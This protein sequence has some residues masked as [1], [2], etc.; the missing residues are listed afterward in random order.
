[1]VGLDAAREAAF[2]T[3]A[4]IQLEL[5]IRNV[6][7]DYAAAQPMQRLR[8]TPRARADFQDMRAWRHEALKINVM[9]VL[10][11]GAEREPVK[12]L[13]FAFPEL[14]E[15]GFDSRGIVGH[16]ALTARFSVQRAP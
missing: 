2:R 13:P 5:D 11:D 6:G 4:T 12:A 16:N 8:E 1:L 9:D 14:I 15:V 7:D 10:V 3:I